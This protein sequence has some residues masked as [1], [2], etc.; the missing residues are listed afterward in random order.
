MS[1]GLKKTNV[2]KEDNGK[3]M[4]DVVKE[5]NGKVMRDV[6]GAMHAK[7]SENGARKNMHTLNR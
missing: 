4:R 5:D 7:E 6:E 1:P 3:V 2:V